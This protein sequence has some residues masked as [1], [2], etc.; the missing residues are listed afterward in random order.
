MYTKEEYKRLW[1]KIKNKLT[2]LYS[3]PNK[4]E[5]DEQEARECGRGFDKQFTDF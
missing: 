5:D 1:P 4:K 3:D 2:A